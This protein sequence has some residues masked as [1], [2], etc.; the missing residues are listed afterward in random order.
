MIR[1]NFLTAFRSFVKN[2]V[3]TLINVFGLAM[4]MACTIVIVLYV[5]D[6][7]SYENQHQHAENIYRVITLG[8]VGD[9]EINTANASL[10]IGGVL[11]QEFPFV[12][13]FVRV[14]GGNNMSV[15]HEKDAYNEQRFYFVDS[16]IAEVFTIP[17]VRGNPG[18]A[19]NRPNTVVITESIAKK[20]FGDDDPMGKRIIGDNDMEFEVTGIVKDVPLNTHFK[21][22][23]LAS[24]TSR[25]G[26]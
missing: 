23:F 16:N 10:P 8:K 18:T 26:V 17:F 25:K 3:Y 12:K 4:G 7:L 24:I 20:Y 15:I 5:I 21:Y 6:E 2:K 14:N 1:N 19:L 13:Q 11:K 22:D 9:N